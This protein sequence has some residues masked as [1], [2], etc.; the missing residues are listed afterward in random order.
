M[1]STK[2]LTKAQIQAFQ[3]RVYDH[4]G[5][6][7]RDFPWRRTHD[8]YHVLVSEIMLQQT[9]AGPRTV[10][11]YKEFIKKFPNVRALAR[12]PL[13]KVLTLWQGLGYNRR[14]KALWE[15]AQIIVEEYKGVFPRKASELIKLPGI[16]TYTAAAIVAFAFNRPATL[17]ETNV[18]TVF[19]YHFLKEQTEIPDT[20]LIPLIEATL[21][22][23]NP[24]IWYTALMDYGAML[25]RTVGNMG[26]Q[27]KHYTKQSSFA[28]S[29]REIRGKI[30]RAL[31]G[32]T[33]LSEKTLTRTIENNSRRVGT[34]LSK[35][36]KEGLVKKKRQLFMLG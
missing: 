7:G 4:Y 20:A 23:K 27:S 2:K 34:L 3:K 11:K 21:D 25:K 31:V 22:H 36:V 5:E 15:A 24:R 13:K 19:I 10:E 6:Q 1:E 9:Q 14:A 26:K 12:A 16:G 33:A 35:L 28:G 18:R 29:D 32:H 17:L 30:V 8:P